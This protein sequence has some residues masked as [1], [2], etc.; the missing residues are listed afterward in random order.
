L[1]K[2]FGE[3]LAKKNPITEIEH[4][5]RWLCTPYQA[6]SLHSKIKG[7]ATVQRRTTESLSHV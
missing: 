4:Q 5:L 1:E 2:L 3:K 6:S 7:F